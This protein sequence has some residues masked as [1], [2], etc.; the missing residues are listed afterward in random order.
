MVSMLGSALQVL[1]L[2]LAAV[3]A[4]VLVAGVKL[5]RERLVNAGYLLVFAVALLLTGCIAL[6]LACMFTE[7]YSIAYV[8]SNYPATDS[9]LKPLYLVSAVWAGRQGSLLLWTWLISLY[10]AAVAWR[11]MRAT[12]DLSSVAL[13]VTEVVVAL[14]AATLV[15]SESNIGR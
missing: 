1:A 15:L 4:V 5:R 9:P 7:D 14:F 12:D 3:A 8:V 2:V 10:G 11:R 6:I 13:G